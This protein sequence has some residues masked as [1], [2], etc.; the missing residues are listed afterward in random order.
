M[1]WRLSANDLNDAGGKSPGRAG[2]TVVGL[3]LIDPMG[4]SLS[5]WQVLFCPFRNTTLELGCNSTAPV[6][7]GKPLAQLADIEVV[8]G[9]VYAAMPYWVPYWRDRRSRR[10]FAST[11]SCADGCASSRFSPMGSPVSWQ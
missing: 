8:L 11:D 1:Y 5:G 7:R 10:S 2:Y 4:Y 9:H 3:S 6:K